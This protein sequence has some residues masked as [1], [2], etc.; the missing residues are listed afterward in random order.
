[1]Q[2]VADAMGV[3]KATVSRA[4]RGNPKCGPVLREKILKKAEEMGYRPDGLQSLHMA[5]LRGDPG[6]VEKGLVIAV[7]D[8]SEKSRWG[9]A[10]SGGGKSML[11]G[12]ASRADS[13]GLK[14]E[15]LTPV[16]DC[17]SLSRLRRI[18]QGRGIRGLI[19]GP[20]PEAGSSLEFDFSGFA[21]IAIGHSL[22]SPR[23]HRVSHNQYSA[24]W[25]AMEALRESGYRRIGLAVGDDIEERIFWRRQAAYRSFCRKHS[26]LA[27]IPRFVYPREPYDA[28]SWRANFGGLQEWVAQH[29][30]EVVIGLSDWIP[31]ALRSGGYKVPGD[32]L[33]FHA[34]LIPG[35]N[36]IEFPG[37]DPPWEQIGA[38]AVEQIFGQW[39]RFEHGVPET[40]IELDLDGK[41][42]L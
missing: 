29:N 25:Q 42:L 35:D 40:P 6:R 27:T 26:D 4:F 18:L 11:K 38:V 36:K 34:S 15:V 13:L 24:M 31:A 39:A 5:R 1:M 28:A 37:I 2:D 20:M 22:E 8:F 23:L 19:I 17:I 3:G 32:I 33:F 14:T 21:T 9:I 30:P 16:R 12:A 10:E 7:L 41:V